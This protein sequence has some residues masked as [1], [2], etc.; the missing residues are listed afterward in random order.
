MLQT[1]ISEIEFTPGSLFDLENQQRI[2]R[3]LI[4]IEVAK[5]KINPLKEDY[6]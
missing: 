4:I 2:I 3:S 6:I 5:S 1:K